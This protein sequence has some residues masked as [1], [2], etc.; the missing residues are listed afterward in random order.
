MLQIMR[1]NAQGTIAK[2][3]VGF[4]I[5]VFALFGVESIVTLG[6]GEKPVAVVGDLEIF[7]VDIARTVAVQKQELQ[8]QFGDQFDDNLFD[9]QFLRNSA[10]ERLIMALIEPNILL[11]ELTAKPLLR[12]TSRSLPASDEEYAFIGLSPN[13]SITHE[14]L[15][16]AARTKTLS[17][18]SPL[19]RT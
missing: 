9:E 6:G 15:R 13:T 7:E 18:L 4:I 11:I 3:I 17:F 19:R 14:E 8:R 16:S 1:D 5:I 12:S 2:I 10:I